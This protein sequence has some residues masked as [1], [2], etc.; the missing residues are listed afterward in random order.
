MYVVLGSCAFREAYHQ[1]D[2]LLL[3]PQILWR[4]NH[5]DFCSINS[6]VPSLARREA[7]E[8]LE[9][10]YGTW[11]EK[12]LGP[13]P[14]LLLDRWVLHPRVPLELMPR[15]QTEEGSTCC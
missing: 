12:W 10:R 15:S 6:M 14:P 7:G 4:H 3:L 5:S 8:F 11:L 2:I 13:L 9:S 1:E